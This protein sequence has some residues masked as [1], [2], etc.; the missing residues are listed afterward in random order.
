MRDTGLGASVLEPIAKRIAGCEFLAVMVAQKGEVLTHAA[1]VDRLSQRRGKRGDKLFLGLA[2]AEA[3]RAILHM[4]RAKLRG[5][6]AARSGE[7]EQHH[8][9]I[10]HA[11]FR[12]AGDESG[13]LVKAPNVEA[14]RLDADFLDR[15]GGVPVEN[16]N[17]H[18]P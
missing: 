10:G 5:V 7:Q 9:A 1:S 12:V 8:G 11:A 16:S 6:I 18:R 17:H 4:L 14:V 15:L 13:D 3:D 2:D